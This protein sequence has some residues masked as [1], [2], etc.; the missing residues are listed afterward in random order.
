MVNVK[1]FKKQVKL[2]GQGN[3]VK[4]YGTSWKVLS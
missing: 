1:V 4:K 2:Q 3:K